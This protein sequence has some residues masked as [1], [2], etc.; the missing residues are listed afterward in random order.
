LTELLVQLLVKSLVVDLGVLT[1]FLALV[2]L[3][4][5]SSIRSALRHRLCLC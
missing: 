2:S 1:V 4:A 3:S 5:H